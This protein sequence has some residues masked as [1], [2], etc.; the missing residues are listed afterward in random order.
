MFDKISITKLVNA[1]V[2]EMNERNEPA[3]DGDTTVIQVEASTPVQISS[4]TTKKDLT[5]V[6][7][8]SSA[9]LNYSRR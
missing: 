7:H 4:K 6:Y 2:I 9:I 8:P 3:Y 1:E 5:S